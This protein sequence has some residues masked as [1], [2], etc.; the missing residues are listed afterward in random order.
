[1]NIIKQQDKYKVESASSKGKFY[2]VDP[3][4]QVCSCPGYIFYAKR[5]GTV[6][7]HIK[8]VLEM[9]EKE[10]IH[11]KKA[12]KENLAKQAESI[13]KEIIN[14]LKENN[15]EADSMGLI[16]KYGEKI[17]DD[18]IQDGTLIEVRGMIKYIE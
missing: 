15:N 11:E 9:L 1:M 10:N 2:I 12:E 8:A 7:K 16:E 17:I 13:R 6:C 3:I 4:K 18:M 5:K 14:Y